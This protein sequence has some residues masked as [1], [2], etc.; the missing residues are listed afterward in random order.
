MNNPPDIKKRLSTSLQ[1]VCE[2]NCQTVYV[3]KTSEEHM[4]SMDKPSIGA[5]NVN[6]LRNS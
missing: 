1:Q 4:F 2:I 6:R 5:V 3:L